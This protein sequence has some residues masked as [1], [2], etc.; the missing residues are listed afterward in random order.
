V[1]V[2]Q[3]DAILKGVAAAVIVCLPLAL[4]SNVVRDDDSSSALLPVLFLA[5]IVGFLFAG[6]VAAR[7]ARDSPYSN[8]AVAALCGFLVIEVVAVVVRVVGDKPLHPGRIVGTGLLAYAAGLLGGVVAT[9]G[10]GGSQEA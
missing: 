6:F 4:V 5:V 3:R 8:G 2:L 10:G 7:S 9:Y 1:N